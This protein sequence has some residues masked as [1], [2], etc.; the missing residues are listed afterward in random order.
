M[1]AILLLLLLLV[2]IKGVLV[3][4]H[5]YALWRHGRRLMALAGDPAS[6]LQAQGPAKV[7]VGLQGIEQAVQGLRTELR[8]ALRPVWLPWPTARE[9]LLTVD[10][11]LGIGAELAQAGQVANKGL[12]SV[13]DAWQVRRQSAQ[14]EQ[15]QDISKAL[16]AGLLD[17]RPHLA[18]AARQVHSAHDSVAAR[19]TGHLWRP[20]A[21]LTD[22]LEG[23]LQ[24]GGAALEAA[25]AAPTLLGES[26]AVNY[27]ILIQNNDELRATGGFITGI[28]LVSVEAGKISRLRMM[29]SYAV[30]KF[31]VDH[32][33]APEPM[34]RY[35][36]IILWVTRD[37][38]WSPDFPTAA[39][40]VEELYHLENST[41]ISGVFAVDML[42]L[43]AIVEAAGP[44]RVG[45]D[46]IDGSNVLAKVKEYRVPEL[47]EGQDWGRQR[48]L[49][50][51]KDHR[52]DFMQPLTEALVSKLQGRIGPQRMLQVLRVVQQ[53]LVEKHVLLHFREPE[54]Q[55]LLEVAGWDGALAESA[56]GD[57][58]L[59]VNTN[60]GYNKV[61][62]NIEE[63]MQYQVVLGADAPAEATLTITYANHSPAQPSCELFQ[64]QK[65]TYEL[66]TQDC[67]WNYLRVYAPT[68]SQL[69]AAEGVTETETLSA[70]GG[71]TVF[72]S[73]LIVPAAETRTV[74]L[75]YS[76]PSLA[77]DGYRLLVQKQAGT[78]AVPLKVRLALPA[79]VRWST[80]QPVPQA[81]EPG[82]LSY[83]LDL[84]QDRSLLLE[85]R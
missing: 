71:K 77:G 29:D 4:R 32:P 35:M 30:D 53:T 26:G 78:E 73:F 24:L 81:E 75:T 38:N 31:T 20:L 60:M 34:Q 14:G 44:L 10:A 6:L 80:A 57:Y 46:R 15:T 62:V 79:G 11:L 68:G 49:D 47:P 83:D 76:L 39:R 43:Q 69:L 13:V 45:S 2:L 28:G 18:E 1:L 51:L 64:K 56:G 7:K 82:V 33:Y 50:W 54:A 12:E 19:A 85:F 67:Y 66:L 25:A 23:Y 8:F 21:E 61:N 63:Q 27:L 55:A 42:A 40:D 41:P 17:A 22:A 74:R 59:V 16:F 5:A 48:I 65:W 36:D 9:N 52:K 84:R 70:E 58:L 72:A 3:G 37:G